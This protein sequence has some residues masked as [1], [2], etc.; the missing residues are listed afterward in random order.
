MPE[1]HSDSL[2]SGMIEIEFKNKEKENARLESG[3]FKV[4]LPF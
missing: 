1:A 2:A 4:D 3:R